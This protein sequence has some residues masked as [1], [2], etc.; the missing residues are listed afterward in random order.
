MYANY[1]AINLI[2]ILRSRYFGRCG[3]LMFN[4]DDFGN[5]QMPSQ[6]ALRQYLVTAYCRNLSTLGSQYDSENNKKKS[7]FQSPSTYYKSEDDH[8]GKQ[9]PTVYPI[10][11]FDFMNLYLVMGRQNKRSRT[12]RY[13]DADK[14]RGEVE[15][16][17][18]LHLQRKDICS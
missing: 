11:H 3:F 9:R 18:G 6:L 2:M 17:K 8:E 4:F 16:K 13:D 7:F 5:D 12:E 15:K 14:E 10:S 1:L